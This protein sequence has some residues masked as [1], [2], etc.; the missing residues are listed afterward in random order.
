MKD[1]I[2]TAIGLGVGGLL[3]IAYAVLI[4]WMT[5]KD[6]KWA[7]EHRRAARKYW[8]AGDASYDRSKANFEESRKIVADGLALVRAEWDRYARM[9]GFTPKQPPAD[10]TKKGG[11]N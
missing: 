2:E 1:L 6:R 11:T 3:G 5:K 10:D 4:R 9:Y 7:A 8:R